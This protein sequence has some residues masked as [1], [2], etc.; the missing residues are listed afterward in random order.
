MM[1]DKEILIQC[2]AHNASSSFDIKPTVSK[3]IALKFVNDH[4]IAP[5]DPILNHNG[6]GPYTKEMLLKYHILNKKQ[7]SD[8]VDKLMAN[9][10]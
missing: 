5:D 2:L 6:V 1:S 4:Q 9:V 8:K 3:N 10:K 7:L